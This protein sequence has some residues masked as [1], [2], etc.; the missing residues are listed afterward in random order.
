MELT[1]VVILCPVGEASRFTRNVGISAVTF[2]TFLYSYSS[3]WCPKERICPFKFV[4][5]PIISCL[6][7]L[8]LLRCRHM[9]RG[10]S[11]AICKHSKKFGI[12]Q[13]HGARGLPVTSRHG[14]S[15][16]NFP[17]LKLLLPA[18]GTQF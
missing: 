2:F 11:F 4:H 5:E 3:I 17:E 9:I 10:N 7:I 1:T 15:T 16:S 14:H 18:E 13:K 6:S 8:T 12:M